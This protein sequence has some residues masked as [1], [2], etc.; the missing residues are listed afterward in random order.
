[1][2][3]D[4][5]GQVLSQD[6]RPATGPLAGVRIIELGG[7]GPGPF[8]AMLLSDMGADVIRVDRPGSDTGLGA[9]DVLRRGRRSIALDLSKPRGV[10]AL[11]QLVESADAL[12][13]G[14]RP[15]VAERIGVGP[16]H[17][18]RRN[19]RLVYGRMTGWGQ[20]GPWSQ[21][22]GHDINYLSLTGA[23]HA[24]GRADQPPTVPLN[25]LGDFGGGSTYLVIGILAAML[26]ARASGRG[27]VVDAAIVDGAASLTTMLHGMLHAGSWTDKRGVNLLDSGTPWYDVYETFDGGW[28]SV[29]PLEAR[30]YRQFHELLG[31]PEEF[32]RRPKPD[33]WAVL[34]K[35][36]AERF[37]TKTRDEW[38]AIFAGTDACVA[39]I[40]TMTEAPDHEHL[41]G[42]EVFVEIEGVRQ[43]AP[44]PRFDRT[45]GAIQRPPAVVGEHTR[46]VLDEWGV[47]DIDTLISEDAAIQA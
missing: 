26:E 16:E 36:I 6:D 5:G 27:Q 2:S 22:A 35:S 20:H 15:G 17:C 8:A 25:V 42:R 19:P 41:R 46:E 23:L 45:P 31:L 3:D 30:F 32:A 9:A 1:M 10:K 34:R 24:I 29:G 4:G 11:L 38:S 40:L 28:V 21:M 7:I 37:R 14:Y 39:P 12:I 13:E 47:R 44:A 18:A 33:G 43:P